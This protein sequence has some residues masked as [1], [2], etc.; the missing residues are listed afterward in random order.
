M[1][2]CFPLTACFH[3]GAKIRRLSKGFSAD[4]VAAGI[5]NAIVPKVLLTIVDMDIG[6]APLQSGQCR[7]L[8]GGWRLWWVVGGFRCLPPI[9]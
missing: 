4:A 3:S 2:D 7:L 5:Y 6:V 1:L 8:F 9:D